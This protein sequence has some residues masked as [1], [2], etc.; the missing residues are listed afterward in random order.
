MVFKIIYNL[1][2]CFY[3]LLTLV[4]TMASSMSRLVLQLL[5]SNRFFT[6]LF[7]SSHLIRSLSIIIFPI[8]LRS[9]IV[10]IWPT[11]FSLFLLYF[12][13]LIYPPVNPILQNPLSKGPPPNLPLRTVQLH[14]RHLASVKFPP[15]YAAN[16]ELYC[17]VLYCIVLYCIVLYCIVLYCIVLKGWSLLPNAL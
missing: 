16:R 2:F 11:H 4:R 14:L 17:I 8:K 10:M 3:G 9:P 12:H 15:P 5:T 6:S 1:N 7:I 13:K